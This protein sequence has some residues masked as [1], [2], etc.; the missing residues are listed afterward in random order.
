MTTEERDLLLSNVKAWME[1]RLAPLEAFLAQMQSEKPS[2]ASE[3]SHGLCADENCTVCTKLQQDLVQQA[4]D[5][6]FET[7]HQSFVDL[8][9]VEISEVVAKRFRELVS[10]QRDPALVINGLRIG[11]PI[12]AGSRT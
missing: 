5:F 4:Q 11:A 3:V 9:L 6:I 8:G 2:T 7:L 12:N 1:P 10:E